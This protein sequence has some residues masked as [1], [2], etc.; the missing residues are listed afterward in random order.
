MRRF[1]AIAVI[2]VPCLAGIGGCRSQQLG[3]DQNQFRQVLLEM[4]EDQLMDNLI[5]A[6]NR[7][8]LL[9]LDYTN[10]TGTVTHSG[11]AS[12]GGGPIG[13]RT[14]TFV[15]PTMSTAGGSLVRLATQTFNYGVTASQIS[16]LTV[17]AN[18]IVDNSGVY[19]AYLN[20]V[21]HPS[22]LI[23]SCDPPPPEAAPVVRQSGK[24]FYWVPV[25]YR[26][27]FLE[28]AL[29]TSGVRTD[30]SDAAAYY[31]SNITGALNITIVPRP[32][33]A[34]IQRDAVVTITLGITDISPKDDGLPN[35]S[36]WM[37][38]VIK[39]REIRFKLVETLVTDLPASE[40][41]KYKDKN[42]GYK[43][44][45]STRVLKIR[46]VYDP[47]GPSK[48]RTDKDDLWSAP[49]E[50]DVVVEAV[51]NRGVRIELDHYKPTA[52]A[53]VDTLGSIRT[54]A[55]LLRLNQLQLLKP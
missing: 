52:P 50:P 29:R 38:A 21:E 48:L 11:S 39:G 44:G 14:T 5:R 12:V 41:A 13:T 40:R 9:H 8:P 54:Q 49:F 7:M 15:K 31:E 19:L 18:P 3:Y 1:V 35:D 30:P 20:F 2:V 17:T 6:K 45:A 23:Q 51:A 34:G 27:E 33:T 53:M 24:Q 46:Y 55:E 47:T 28:V 42:D 16:Q 22:R 36:G 43:N 4:Y 25:E 32:T 10:I 26:N 37:T